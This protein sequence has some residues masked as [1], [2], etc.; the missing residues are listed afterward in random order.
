MPWAQGCAGTATEGRE[1][2]S[3]QVSTFKSTTLL[4][5]RA[6]ATLSAS[7]SVKKCYIFLASAG[8]ALPEAISQQF[9]IKNK[10]PRNQIRMPLCHK[11]EEYGCLCP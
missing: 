10:A 2:L 1:R 8:A 11:G 9:T 3:P 7:I 5:G 4:Q 6:R